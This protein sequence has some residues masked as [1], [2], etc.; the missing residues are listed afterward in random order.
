LKSHHDWEF[1]G[2][3]LRVGIVVLALAAS[4]LAVP[5]NASA[6]TTLNMSDLH[7]SMTVPTGWTYERNASSGG[8]IYDLE[9]QGPLSGGYQPYGLMDHTSWPG[10]VSNSSLWAEMK[11]EKDDMRDDPE[12]SY[13]TVLSAATNGTIN[14]IK[15][16]DMII[17][18]TYSGITITERLV[19]LASGDWNMGWKF[20]VA[21]VSSQWSTYSGVVNSMVDSLTVAEHTG[22]AEMSMAI[23]GGIVLIAVVVV[24]V[25]VVFVMRGRG[26]KEEPM[27][28]TPAPPSTPPTWQQVQGPP[29]PPPS[30]P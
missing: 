17:Q 4:L 9:L 30:S 19:I 14:G 6:A 26:R 5:L 23:L 18:V 3:W 28:Y 2:I 7:I 16:N 22:G 24:I 1:G 10:T 21:T 12:A 27:P 11:K 20:V 25:V 15:S 29:P 13:F 8:V